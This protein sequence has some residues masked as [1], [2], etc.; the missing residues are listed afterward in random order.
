M[1]GNK[2]LVAQS[3]STSSRIKAA[4]HKK[5]S[6]EF[7]LEFFIPEKFIENT[8]LPS[9][10]ST[11][12]EGGKMNHELHIS[13]EMTFS[14]QANHHSISFPMAPAASAMPWARPWENRFLHGEGRDVAKASW[15]R[16]ETPLTS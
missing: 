5:D 12:K 11:K 7:S 4:C 2:I 13:L 15:H 1:G 14:S 16:E 3:C 8:E 6:R 10:R 9:K